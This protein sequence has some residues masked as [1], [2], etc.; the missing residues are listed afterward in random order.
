MKWIEPLLV[1]AVFGCSGSSE[2][3]NAKTYEFA[4]AE[5]IFV[6]LYPTSRKQNG[7]WSAAITAGETSE[8]VVPGHFL[9]RYYAS[10]D[11]GQGVSEIQ[12]TAIRLIGWFDDSAQLY[13]FPIASTE[14]ACA[15]VTPFDQIC[16]EP[17]LIDDINFVVPFEISGMDAKWEERWAF[18]HRPDEDLEQ[19]PPSDVG[20]L[21]PDIIWLGRQYDRETYQA[22]HYGD[23]EI[24]VSCKRNLIDGSPPTR[25]SADYRKLPFVM[26][27]FT[28]PRNELH[29]LK[30]YYTAVDET[31]SGFFASAKNRREAG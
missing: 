8:L 19:S 17:E 1:M 16:L 2:A 21:L 7:G 4:P 18:S 3:D 12:T 6:E 26:V 5:N 24:F 14:T 15:S 23:S 10:Y 20:E 25:C 30:M 13:P 29:D 27:S 11:V 28:L 9:R 31:V 22:V